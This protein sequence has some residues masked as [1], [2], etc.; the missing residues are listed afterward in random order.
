MFDF[1]AKAVMPSFGYRFNNSAHSY[2]ALFIK[3]AVP[4]HGT[5]KNPLT[6]S[7]NDEDAEVLTE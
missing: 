7:G 2:N 5:M 6:I 4:L 3:D 1:N